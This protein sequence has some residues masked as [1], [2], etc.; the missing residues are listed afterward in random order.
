MP[1][2]VSRSA[3]AVLT[4]FEPAVSALTGQRDRPLH[5]KTLVVIVDPGGIASPVL[6]NHSCDWMTTILL[7]FAR[8]QAPCR[9]RHVLLAEA[10]NCLTRARMTDRAPTAWMM[11]MQHPRRLVLDQRTHVQGAELLVFG[12]DVAHVCANYGW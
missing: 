9:G 11:R 4:G 5:H 7:V 6:L 2:V 3:C 10:R 8:C 12:V 1:F